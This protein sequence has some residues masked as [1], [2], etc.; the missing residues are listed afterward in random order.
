MTRQLMADAITPRISGDSVRRMLAR[1][2]L[3]PWRKRMWLS[4]TVPRDA[5]FAAK[6]RR[7]L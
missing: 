2:K 5:A 3:K 1:H 7:M 6:V 4:P